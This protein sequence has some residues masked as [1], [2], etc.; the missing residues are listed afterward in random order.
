MGYALALGKKICGYVCTLESLQ[1]RVNRIEKTGCGSAVDRAG[2]AIESFNLPLNLMLAA[3]TQIVEG[4]L[5]ACLKALRG[6]LSAIEKPPAY[7]L[8]PVQAADF[9]EDPVARDAQEAAIRY[10]RWV[11]EGR[12]S[13]Q[14]SIA[15]VADQ[16]KVKEEA[17]H[18]WIDNWAGIS[19]ATQVEYRPDDVTRWMKISG[20]QYR[21]RK[22]D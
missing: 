6:H 9:P 4:G 18:Q 15:T 12:I 11:E 10:L 1:S 13:D 5:E 22:F 2:M 16:Y 8:T 14:N 21:G 17:V 19:T 3:P 7:Q 20:R